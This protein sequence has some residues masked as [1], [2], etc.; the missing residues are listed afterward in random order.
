MPGTSPGMTF[1]ETLIVPFHR[2]RPRFCASAAGKR[3]RIV[4]ADGVSF[5][6]R[7]ECLGVIGP[8]GAGRA[9]C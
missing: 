1:V 6:A 2:D 3:W 5:R 8:N 7:G 4:V 9:R